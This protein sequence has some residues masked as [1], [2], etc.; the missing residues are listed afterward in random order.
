VKDD[1]QYIARVT[2][3]RL[4][5]RYRQGKYYADRFA[6]MTADQ[7]R[8]FVRR[9][10]RSFRAKLLLLL[11]AAIFIPTT[12]AGIYLGI[13]LTD[14]INKAFSQQL[15]TELTTFG[16]MLQNEWEGLHSVL[17]RLATD[18]TVQKNI[19]FETGFIQRYLNEQRSV[20]QLDWL[21]LHEAHIP[22]VT[23]GEMGDTLLYHLEQGRPQLIVRDADR[24]YLS[25]TVA[26]VVEGDTLGLLTGGVALGDRQSNLQSIFNSDKDRPVIWWKGDPITLSRSTQALNVSEPTTEGFLQEQSITDPS[27]VGISRT[28]AVDG[29]RLKLSIYRNVDS[30]QA[31]MR[32]TVWAIIATLGV[33]VVLFIY[34][35]LRMV[36]TISR[37]LNA[38]TGYTRGLISDNFEPAATKRLSELSQTSTDEIGELASAFQSMQQQLEQYIEDLKS[39]TER[40]ERINSEL[41]IA[42]NIQMNMLPGEEEREAFETAFHVDTAIRPARQVGGDLYDLFPIGNHHYAVVIG[43]VA[44]KG[45]PAALFMAMSKTLVRAITMLEHQQRGEDVQPHRILEQMGRELQRNNKMFMFVTLFLGIVDTKNEVLKYAS[46]GHN[47]PVWIPQGELAQWLEQEHGVPLGIRKQPRYQA[48]S[49]PFGSGDRLL[50]YTDGIVEAENPQEEFFGEEPFLTVVNH[51]LE[52]SNEDEKLLDLIQ[53]QVSEFTSGKE[54]S[55]DQTLLLL[56]RKPVPG[57]RNANEEM[58]PTRQDKLEEVFEVLQDYLAEESLEEQVAHDLSLI[59]EEY[60][61]NLLKYG[62]NDEQNPHI[63]V[64]FENVDEVIQVEVTD[65]AA[66]FNPNQVSVAALKER[67]ASREPGKHGLVIIHSLAESIDYESQSNGNRCVI[68]YKN[69]DSTGA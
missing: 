30:F 66:A 29:G 63:E 60:V 4:R 54:Q 58:Q 37:P 55:D 44:D 27:L 42:R 31:T 53:Q 56:Q 14:Q 35:G 3:T 50:L 48:Q 67:S 45:V 6:R 41:R 21:F 46:A 10:R 16:M 61:V 65:N 32:N 15:D 57:E 38:L 17:V 19:Q 2:R 18:N 26:I 47:P 64:S 59:V 39:A 28:V 36:N 68:R 22:N 5:R 7:I 24:S 40:Q 49:V 51:W 52:D 33:I 9:V 23:S 25:S 69:Q 62:F 1:L 12:I 20:S 13:R 8:A 43:D 34:I 11:I